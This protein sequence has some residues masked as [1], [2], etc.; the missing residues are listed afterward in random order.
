HGPLPFLVMKQLSGRSLAEELHLRSGHLSLGHAAAVGAELCEAVEALHQAGVVLSNLQPRQ[1]HL[2]ST[3]EVVLIDLGSARETSSEL[4][5]S[6]EVLAEAG[7]RAPEVLAGGEAD[8]RSDVYSLGC[9]VYELV[10]G[11]PPFDGAL[12]EVL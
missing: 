10:A 9:V 4:T 8:V 6:G 7:Y 5:R 1:V 2:E 12:F 11:R 3:G